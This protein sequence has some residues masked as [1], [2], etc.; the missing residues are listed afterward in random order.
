MASLK[1]YLS[2][3]VHAPAGPGAGL[4]HAEPA[5]PAPARAPAAA[6]P[7]DGDAEDAA[8]VPGF[9]ARVSGVQAQLQGAFYGVFTEF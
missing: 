5:A 1:K 4:A 7:G 9:M 6:A 8:R 3:S 2:C